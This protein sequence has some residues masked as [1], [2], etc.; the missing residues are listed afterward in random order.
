MNMT[1]RSLDP[2][3]PSQPGEKHRNANRSF[4]GIPGIVRLP[5][6]NYFATWY[7]GGRMECCENYVILALGEDRGR[8]WREPV[9]VVDPPGHEVRAFDPVLWLSPQGRLYWFW[10]QCCGCEDGISGDQYDGIAG[11]CFSILEN[12]EDAPA[13][14]RFTPARRIANGVMMNKPTVLADG[15]WAL[16]VT[17]FTGS[18]YLDHSSLNVQQGWSFLVS[19]DRGATFQCR[20]TIAMTAIP[21]GACCEE[22]S[23]IER[24]DGS[25]VCYMRVNAGVAESISVDRGFTW[26]PPALSPAIN[27][28]NSRACFCRLRSGRLLMLNHDCPRYQPGDPAWRQRDNLT[29]YLSDD[30]GQTW[31]HKLRLDERISVSYPDAVE[32]PAGRLS[33]VYDFSRYDGGYIHWAWITEEDI[34][35]G[36]L[37][38]PE[39]FLRHEISHTRPVGEA[40]KIPIPLPRGEAQ[41]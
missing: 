33:I 15:T 38:S 19:T 4:Q 25:I 36:V 16:P 26:T 31:P 29:A 18:K 37:V 20:A 3:T 21:G 13:N 22:H 32:D 8:Q 11:V 17:V 40:A 35:A 23:F 27:G 2:V 39:S 7:S 5:N 34:L 6:G 12:P 1:Y 9:A 14:Y 24:H 41:A 28:P 10:S 30:E